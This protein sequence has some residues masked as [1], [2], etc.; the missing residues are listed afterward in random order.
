[1][2]RTWLQKAFGLGAESPTK[3]LENFLAENLLQAINL[4]AFLQSTARYGLGSELKEKARNWVIQEL[5]PRI[6]DE[7][8]GLEKIKI[9]TSLAATGTLAQK[10]SKEEYHTILRAFIGFAVD[11]LLAEITS[12]KRQNLVVASG[13]ADEKL[14][15]ELIRL[16]WEK[17]GPPKSET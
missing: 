7:E 3:V 8:G 12:S 4:S 5:A 16:L 11:K 15:D 17:Y 9:E 13:I 2:T 14:R 1:M 10:Y 6:Q